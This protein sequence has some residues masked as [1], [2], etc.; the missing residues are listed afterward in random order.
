MKI[1]CAN[2][3]ECAHLL[4]GG[5][6][7]GR[8]RLDVDGDAAHLAFDDEGL[9]GVGVGAQ[10]LLV[11]RPGSGGDVGGFRDFQGVLPFG[12]VG[13]VELAGGAVERG[14]GAGGVVVGVVEFDVSAA[15]G[16]TSFEIEN[17]TGDG[18]VRE[19]KAINLSC[20]KTLI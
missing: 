11:V 8:L 12:D 3:K 4:R 1:V 13:E 19:S 5:R 16:C 17:G 7:G 9:G 18:A 20:K 15:D 10:R 14:D 2:R 6:G